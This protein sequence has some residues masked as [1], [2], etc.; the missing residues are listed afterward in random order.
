MYV[1]TVDSGSDLLALGR[2]GPE[3]HAQNCKISSK[4]LK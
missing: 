4:D 2:E 3:A 1:M